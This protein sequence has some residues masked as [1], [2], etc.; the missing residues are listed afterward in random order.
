[1][2]EELTLPTAPPTPLYAEVPAGAR[3]GMIVLHEIFG[4]Q[5]E[6]DRVVQRFA[7][8]GYAAAAPDLFAS[9]KLLCIRNAVRAIASGKGEQLDQIRAARDWL[10]KRAGL[11]ASRVGLIGFCM[12]GGFALAAGPGFAAVS[13]NYGDVPPTEV[14]RGIGP[15]IGCYGGRDRIFGHNQDK[16][17]KRLLRLGVTPEVHVFPT[18]GHSFLTDGDHPIALF[19]SAPLLQANH[20]DPAVRAEA[21]GKILAFFDR[22]LP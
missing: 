12:G 17:R 5:P 20:R 2:P 19:L 21:W 18:V 7:A 8:A 16:L 6:I 11:E 1:M 10:C 14:M 4:R 3:R 9:G 13:T 22:S 15:V